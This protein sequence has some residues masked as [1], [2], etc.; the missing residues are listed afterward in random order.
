VRKLRV[1]SVR[2]LGS[3]V[4]W[5]CEGCLIAYEGVGSGDLCH[6]CRKPLRKAIKAREN[7]LVIRVSKVGG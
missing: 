3:K 5:V 6:Y 1:W 7:M 2:F 4:V